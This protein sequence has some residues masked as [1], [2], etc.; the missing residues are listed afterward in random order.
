[1]DELYNNRRIPLPEGTAL[2]DTIRI[3]TLLSDRGGT[4]LTYLAERNGY[5]LVVKE[6]FPLRS[7][8]P[9]VRDGYCIR[10][11]TAPGPEREAVL[12]KLARDFADE[13]DNA[14]LLCAAGNGAEDLALP[15][16]N[17]N[18]I[19]HFPCEDI[20]G[21]VVR[22]P[23]F[24]GTA[25]RYLAI[26]TNR[27]QTLWDTA[28]QIGA[29]NPEGDLTLT[30][31][32]TLVRA[33]LVSLDRMH[34]E[35]GM[36]HLDLKGDNLFF[37]SELPWD[38]TYCILLD[39][40]GARKAGQ[41]T[42]AEDLSESR[43]Y[44]AFEVQ[45]VAKYAP[46]GACPDAGNVRKYLGLIGPHTDLYAVGAIA[47]RL[48][49]GREFDA[50]Q[51]RQINGAQSQKTVAREVGEALRR[52]LAGIH[53]PYLLP[54]LSDMF[55]RALYVPR[56]P[57][58]RQE[59]ERNRYGSCRDFLDDVDVLLEILDCRGIHPEV[60]ADRSRARFLAALRE[61]GVPAAEG[62]DPIRDE[63]LFC[64]DWFPK[65]TITS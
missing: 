62:R 53:R 65:I 24:S 17:G 5:C 49:Q 39:C 1:M 18:S 12:E 6:S 45:K 21:Q 51:W 61:N 19:F 57:R 10:P 34:R 15:G 60:I 13:R 32:L 11:E 22:Q 47:W 55:C 4:A 33:V 54:R 20:T 58:D 29:G 27:G 42:S 46:G 37:P 2:T 3:R 14:V 56:D 44:A 43:G 64:R 28:E 59:L 26:H 31:A 52:R 36:L 63:E 25:A 8:V 9:L 48:I 30:Q 35:T 23:G 16:G 41:I 50:V 7:A 40:G 38:R